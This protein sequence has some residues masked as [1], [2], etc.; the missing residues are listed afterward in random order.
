MKQGEKKVE[1]TTKNI[2]NIWDRVY[3]TDYLCVTTDP[4]LSSGGLLKQ[5]TT[6]SMAYKQQKF[7]SHSFG[8]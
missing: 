5:N 1:I 8:G 4:C 7:V 2:S 3:E 6:D